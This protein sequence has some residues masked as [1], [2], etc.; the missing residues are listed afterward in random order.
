MT[1]ENNDSVDIV[2]I[3]GRGRVVL[4]VSDH[5]DWSDSAEH[6]RI[7]QDKLNCYLRFVE[8]GEILEKYSSARGRAIVLEVTF[9]Y[10]PNQEGRLFL[11]RVA[12][13]I[14]SAGF[15][16]HHKV[17]ADSHDN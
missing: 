7:L 11:Q 9:K 5:L 8:S 13:I 17:F 4:T 2:S 1:V 10:K 12:E 3:D 16:F 6:Q 15:D 14:K